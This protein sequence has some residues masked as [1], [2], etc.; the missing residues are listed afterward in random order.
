[1]QGLLLKYFVLKPASKNA[2]DDYAF[3]SRKAMLTFATYCN[4]EELANDLRE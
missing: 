2:K 1:M 4:N 3:A